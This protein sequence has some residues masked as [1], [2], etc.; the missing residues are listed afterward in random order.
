MFLAWQKVIFLALVL[1]PI[2]ATLLFH[3]SVYIKNLSKISIIISL[4]CVI[5]ISPI[6]I[7]IDLGYWSLLL[8]I[9]PIIFRGIGVT[10]S[11][12][13]I[14]NIHKIF[15]SESIVQLLI[16]AISSLVLILITIDF[17]M[18]TGLWISLAVIIF[19]GT[20][21]MPKI[22]NYKLLYGVIFGALSFIMS[23]ILKD[24]KG[25]VTYFISWAICTIPFY[26]IPIIR[27]FIKYEI[28]PFVLIP[29]ITIL[30]L[31]NGGISFVWSKFYAATFLIFII[32][33]III[34]IYYIVE[35]FKIHELNYWIKQ[36]Y[37]PLTLIIMEFILIY[38]KNKFTDFNNIV[39]IPLIILN[40]ETLIISLGRFFCPIIYKFENLHTFIKIKDI[41]NIFELS[42]GKKISNL[43]HT[44][45]IGNYYDKLN[46]KQIC[47]GTTISIITP[48]CGAWL[49]SENINI[50][51]FISDLFNL[52]PT[53]NILAILFMTVCG[54]TVLDSILKIIY[55]QKYCTGL[56][57]DEAS[58]L[59]ST[60]SV[61]YLYWVIYYLYFF[62][63]NIEKINIYVKLITILWLFTISFTAHI[64][65]STD[66]VNSKYNNLKNT[67]QYISVFLYCNSF[68]IAIYSG[69]TDSLQLLMPDS[70]INIFNRY[71]YI[72]LICTFL[73]KTI[74][75]DTAIASKKMRNKHIRDCIL[76][77]FLFLFSGISYIIIGAI[78]M[79][80]S[81][82]ITLTR[83]IINFMFLSLMLE[84]VKSLVIAILPSKNNIEES[85]TDYIILKRARIKQ[86]NIT[87][88]NQNKKH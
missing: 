30:L 41:H 4:I 85:L 14:R 63:P 31:K 70:I 72:L 56:Q 7:L 54:F 64:Y 60:L 20:L 79:N 24:E 84:F 16:A 69:L 42:F 1:L 37:L 17:N 87:K 65:L 5:F 45:I 34:C 38:Y 52:T 58:K 82:N 21:I 50:N 28:I 10:I 39:A 75:F 40:I 66:L 46:T 11:K 35:K 22:D 9:L 2:L 81:N 26:C 36:Y 86:K 32:H 3:P 88:R 80:L 29:I 51:A 78:I 77:F 23:L 67:R 47:A 62:L 15:K 12:L 13:N 48:I 18:W 83:F 49:V 57:Q 61:N 55:H 59:S 19:S 71:Y 44:L 73:C 25:L 76:Q 74:G 43:L 6:I 33:L 68:F 27:K 53:F 8:I